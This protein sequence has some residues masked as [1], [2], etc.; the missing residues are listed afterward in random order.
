[1]TLRQLEILR[2]LIRC[3][4]TIAAAEAL[5]LSQPA[6]SNALK[7]MEAQA[8]FALFERINNRLFPTRE[9]IA[10]AED[11]ETIFNL[12]A[13]L[14]NRVRDLRESRAGVL[15]LAATP[16]LGHGVIAG[17]LRAFLAQRPKV[18]VF[19][20]VKRFEGVTDSLENGLA[21]IGFMLGESEGLTLAKEELHGG[22]MVCV[23]PPDHPLT[24]KAV[25]TPADLAPHPFIALERGTRMGEAVRDSFGQ[26]DQPF[27]FAVEVRYCNTACIL[28]ANGVGAAVV[29]PYSPATGPAQ[30]LEVRPFTPA[31]RTAAYAAWS[32]NRPLS[33]LAEAFLRDMRRAM[34]PQG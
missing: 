2:A 28:A 33:R 32:P 26:A 7:Q 34:N 4:T 23:M 27:V 15:R 5:R 3:R 6:V 8:G 13:R 10:L 17:L 11:A 31:T 30:H 24:A 29:D 18:R 16:P 1:M 22:D 21:D 12:H 25:V 14:E 19:L 20:D 9:A